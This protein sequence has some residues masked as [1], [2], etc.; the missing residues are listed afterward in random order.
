MQGCSKLAYKIEKRGAM[1][2]FIPFF[3][4]VLLQLGMLTLWWIIWFYFSKMSVFLRVCV[5]LLFIGFLIG[6]SVNAL[7]YY[8][9][10]GYVNA[11]EAFLYLGP[12]K[13]YPKR[14]VLSGLEEIVIEQKKDGW[15]YVSSSQGKG[16]VQT[17]DIA[18]EGD[19]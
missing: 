6:W 13:S 10:R 15:Y 7:Y 4:F 19:T 14:G 18:V 17:A 11:Q 16:W 8:W 3:P 2:N 9:P 1:M 12:E 5:L